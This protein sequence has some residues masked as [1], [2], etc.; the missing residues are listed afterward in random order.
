MKSLT[1]F[2]KALGASVAV[3]A[4]GVI[5]AGL[6]VGD[7]RSEMKACCDD[8]A[9]KYSQDLWSAM[10]K[11]GLAGKGARADTPY[12]GMAPH[13]AILETITS[14]VS[15]GAHKGKVIVKRNYGGDG[16]SIDA[17]SKDRAKF[18]GAVTVMF[19]REAGYDKDNGDWFWVKYKADGSLHTNPK[20]MMLAGRVMKGA[21]KGCIACHAA[22]KDNDYVF[23][24]QN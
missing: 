10:T 4:G 20:G 12:K 15:V 18:L 2:R 8:A 7:A 24:K 11:A 5:L 9:V 1:S 19:K 22:M 3:A 21:D 6:A 17:V 13:G 16:V 23:G 14:E